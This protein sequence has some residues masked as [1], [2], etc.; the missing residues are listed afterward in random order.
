M[1]SA[2]SFHSA[3]ANISCVQLTACPEQHRPTAASPGGTKAAPLFFWTEPENVMQQG[4]ELQHLQGNKP[5]PEQVIKR[6]TVKRRGSQPPPAWPFSVSVTLG[7]HRQDVTMCW[8]WVHSRTPL[9]SGHR[10]LPSHVVLLAQLSWGVGSRAG[11]LATQGT[12]VPSSSAG[13]THSPASSHPQAP[14]GYCHRACALPR[15]CPAPELAVC[16]S[17]TAHRLRDATGVWG[18]LSHA[19]TYVPTPLHPEPRQTALSFTCLLCSWRCPR[20]EAQVMP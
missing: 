7:K 2:K 17:V 20:S 6:D 11:W 15:Q 9:P 5:T 1:D 18:L 8:F 4:C 10:S 3:Q 13:G 16:P 19:S 12:P 14:Q